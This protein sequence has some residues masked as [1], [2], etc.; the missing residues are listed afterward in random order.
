MV[1][2]VK[3]SIKM[4]CLRLHWSFKDKK[5]YL[6]ACNINKNGFKNDLFRSIT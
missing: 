4:D 1:I 3:K 5:L 6:Y 2:T